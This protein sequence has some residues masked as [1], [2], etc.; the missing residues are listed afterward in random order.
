MAKI[1]I[2][3]GAPGA[4]KTTL[5][6]MIAAAFD[7]PMFSKDTIKCL[8]ADFI[9]GDGI[10][11]TQSLGRS[12]IEILR[13]MINEL[14]KGSGAYIFESA[15]LKVYDDDFFKK[16]NLQKKD[17]LQLYC[18]VESSLAY[19]RIKGRLESE[20]RHSCHQDHLRLNEIKLAIERDDYDKLQIE[21][22]LEIE[23]ND[24]FILDPIIEKIE[25]FLSK[26]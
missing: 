19:S 5:A 17:L 16:L 12:S 3:S 22:T 11:Y 7:L 23:I 8:M 21:N 15:F 20:K 4:G 13:L 10:N 25:N 26:L 6:K 9:V 1:I 18:K 2:I 14:S 24:S